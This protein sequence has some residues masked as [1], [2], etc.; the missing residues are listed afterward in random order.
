MCCIKC[1]EHSLYS[2]LHSSLEFLHARWQFRRLQCLIGIPVL[3][4][5]DRSGGDEEVPQRPIGLWFIDAMRK[6]PCYLDGKSW[7]ETISWCLDRTM[8]HRI[9]PSPDHPSEPNAPS[10]FA[11]DQAE[12]ED[13]NP[14][15]PKELAAV[16]MVAICC[17]QEDQAAFKAAVQKVCSAK[18]G[19][20]AVWEPDFE[21][22]VYVFTSCHRRVR[23]PAMLIVRMLIVHMPAPLQCMCCL[24]YKS[25]IR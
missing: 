3:T 11:Y 4:C 14:V 9:H 6:A 20:D 5:R 12:D 7:Y 17:R 8:D 24:I 21:I 22:G 10:S 1:F 18:S 25:H 16:N 15:G 19:E 13:G 23:S 2:I